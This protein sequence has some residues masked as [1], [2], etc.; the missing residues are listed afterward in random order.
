MLCN[1]VRDY[2]IVSSQ[3]KAKKGT[4]ESQRDGLWQNIKS[5]DHLENATINDKYDADDFNDF[6]TVEQVESEQNLLP[7]I[8]QY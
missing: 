2:G 7:E 6:T 1:Y 4:F 3:G 5:S 8:Y